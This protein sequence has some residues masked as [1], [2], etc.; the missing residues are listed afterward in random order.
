MQRQFAEL[1]DN[2]AKVTLARRS[3]TSCHDLFIFDVDVDD[4]SSGIRLSDR[5]EPRKII[6]RASANY[7]TICS[8]FEKLINVFSCSN[9]TADLCLAFRRL[10]NFQNDFSIRSMSG[11]RVEIDDMQ[12]SKPGSFP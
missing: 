8:Y 12:R 7:H 6:D 1:R 11:G 3:P 10:Q 5:H 2:K 9:A 4:Y